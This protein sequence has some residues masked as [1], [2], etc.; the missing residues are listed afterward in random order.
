MPRFRTKAI[1]P[2]GKDIND[3]IDAAD[4]EA[5]MA[6]IWERGLT[7]I[8]VVEVSKATDIAWW[9]RDISFGRTVSTEEMAKFFSAFAAL[10]EARLPTSEIVGFLTEQSTDGKLRT[11]LPSIVQELENGRTLA[12]AMRSVAK[13][14]PERVLASVEIGE[15]SNRLPEAISALAKTLS[16]EADIHKQIRT[17]L[18][19]P[20]VLMILAFAVLLLVIFYLAPTLFQVFEGS[21]TAPPTSLANLVAA[22]DFLVSW[23]I[24]LLVGLLLSIT[25]MFWVVKTNGHRYGNAL[26]KLPLIGS[27]KR[28]RVSADFAG[29][30]AAL[31]DSGAPLPEAVETLHRSAQNG[32]LRQLLQSISDQLA[33]G[34]S[35]TDAIAN[36]LILDPM[37]RRSVSFAEKSD[38]LATVLKVTSD[39]LTDAANR[40]LQ[41]LVA[42]LTP[43]L[44]IVIGLAVGGLILTTITAVLDL[45][46]AVLP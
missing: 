22:R 1:D 20:V 34:S 4:R 10:A 5:A 39:A 30:L 33:D 32:Y 11:V 15:A 29:G 8:E 46:Q 7:P 25:L 12:Q 37:L 38:S 21:P 36:D 19:Y 6:R 27:I 24:E 3:H 18:I 16:K 40:K 35:L 17:A 14:F 2:S 23:W 31:L 26:F 9:Q 43:V 44:T 41:G 42:T 45:N 28:Q 13:V